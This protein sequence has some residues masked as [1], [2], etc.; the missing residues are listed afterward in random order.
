MDMQESMNARLVASCIYKMKSNRREFLRTLYQTHLLTEFCTDFQPN[1]IDN[2]T[3]RN[4]L[5]LTNEGRSK[6][7]L[8]MF[9]WLKL[10]DNDFSEFCFSLFQNIREEEVA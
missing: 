5:E 10:E 1:E 9:Y 4:F 7:F 8:E 2:E 3:A 6:V